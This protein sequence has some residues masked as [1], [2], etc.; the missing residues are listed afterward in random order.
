MKPTSLSALSSAQRDKEKAESSGSDTGNEEEEEEE[1]EEEEDCGICGAHGTLL[2]CDG[3]T[4]SKDGCKLAVHPGCYKS[5]F[6]PPEGDWYCDRCAAKVTLADAKVICCPDKT[7]PALRRTTAI[8][9]IK[10]PTFIHPNCALWNSDVG[11]AK[12]DDLVKIV[13]YL[14]NVAHPCSIC[15][16]KTG[17]RVKCHRA[18]CN[19]FFHVSCA[20]KEE[21]LVPSRYKNAKNSASLILCVDHFHGKK[22]A[23]DSGEGKSGERPASAKSSASGGGGGRSGDLK[24][25]EAA[26][27]EKKKLMSAQERADKSAGGNS[28][29]TKRRVVDSDGSDSEQQ[30]MGKKQRRGSENA[31]TVS[32]DYEDDKLESEVEDEEE[33]AGMI[34]E[35]SSSS[36][37][38][39]A[40]VED[41]SSSKK[42]KPSVT[43]LS[44]TKLA[45]DIFGKDPAAAPTPLNRPKISTLNSGNSGVRRTSESSPMPKPRPGFARPRDVPANGEQPSADAINRIIRMQEKLNQELKGL[46]PALGGASS[47]T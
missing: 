12:G 28:W 25:W 3:E 10:D 40:N 31:K 27:E 22:T 15:A 18:T 14:L 32:S 26:K 29:A 7:N 6:T 30:R 11:I 43:P 41:A 1:D 45:A 16:E 33:D 17:L 44:S 46:L 5:G 4:S 36:S 9:G 42:A 20:I 13:P 2:L 37:K 21:V 38:K 47:A 19:S 8:P 35:E 34:V 39:A 23:S 24:D